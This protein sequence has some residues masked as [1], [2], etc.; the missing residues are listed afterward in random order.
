MNNKILNFNEIPLKIL[1]SEDI[2]CLNKN[3]ISLI[4]NNSKDILEKN[5]INYL[6]FEKNL[7]K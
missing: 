1:L 7:E 6:I 3:N 5:M 2:N 4:K